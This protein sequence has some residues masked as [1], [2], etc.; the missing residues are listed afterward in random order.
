MES[1][2]FIIVLWFLCRDTRAFC[3]HNCQ[4]TRLNTN[5]S[6]C[7]TCLVDRADF[8]LVSA[9][10]ASPGHGEQSKQSIVLMLFYLSRSPQVKP[11]IHNESV[12]V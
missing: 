7:H 8:H 4:H 3:T 6:Y 12:L 2:S 10:Y 1:V 5:V 9:A 11:A